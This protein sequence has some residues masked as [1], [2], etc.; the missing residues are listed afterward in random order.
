MEKLV[1]AWMDAAAL[2]AQIRK[3]ELV[4]DWEALEQADDCGPSFSSHWN[5]ECRKRK[6]PPVD[7]MTDDEAFLAWERATLGV[8]RRTG[9]VRKLGDK[10]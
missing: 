7:G 10:P 5:G 6:R 8:D 4:G 9:A 3:S 1:D 2:A